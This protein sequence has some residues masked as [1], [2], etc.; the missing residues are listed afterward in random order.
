VLGTE[1]VCLAVLCRGTSP[2]GQLV[3]EFRGFDQAIGQH[4]VLCSG[5]ASRRDEAQGA[6]RARANVRVLTPFRL[7]LDPGSNEVEEFADGDDR[8]S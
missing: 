6:I 2:A 5:H 8:R 1:P 3:E 4:Q 7:F